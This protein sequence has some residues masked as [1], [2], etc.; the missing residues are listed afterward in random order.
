GQKVTQR[1]LAILLDLVCSDYCDRRRRVRGA[2]HMLGGTV[3]LDVGQFLKAG[4]RKIPGLLGDR[5]YCKHQQRKHFAY[6]CSSSATSPLVLSHLCVGHKRRSEV[7]LLAVFH[8]PAFV[9]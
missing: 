3:N 7:E 5:Y 1:A 6:S 9:S 8:S 2:L 4:F